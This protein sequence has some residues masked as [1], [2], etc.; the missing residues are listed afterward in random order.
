MCVLRT[1]TIFGAV[2]PSAFNQI[3]AYHRPRIFALA[4][5]ILSDREEAADVT[6]TVFIRLWDRQAE[7]DMDR[8]DAW[9][10]RVARNAAI[11]AWRRR[12]TREGVLSTDTDAVEQLAA[13]HQ[14][15]PDAGVA[16][17]EF[18]GRLRI[19][20]GQLPEPQR[21]IVVLREIEGY[22]YDEIADTLDLPLNTVKVYL[23]R[24]RR[25]LRETLRVYS[26]ENA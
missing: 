2:S 14:E 24:A 9:L 26:P 23:H 18:R 4:W 1:Q 16:S 5:H 15:S 21:S 3:V 17:S 8:V 20:V 22:Q 10:L 25:R 12:R 11:D 6:Q 19:A 7:I 13:A